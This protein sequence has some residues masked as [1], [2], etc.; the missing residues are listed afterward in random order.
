MH[1]ASYL[2]QTEFVQNQPDK[3]KKALKQELKQDTQDQKR[4]QR[5]VSQNAHTKQVRQAISES[6]A[7]DRAQD[8]ICVCSLRGLLDCCR[9]SSHRSAGRRKA[10]WVSGQQCNQSFA[11]VGR[12]NSCMAD[13]TIVMHNKVSLHEWP[14]LYVLSIAAQPY[15]ELHSFH[16]HKCCPCHEVVTNQQDLKF[17]TQDARELLPRFCI[18]VYV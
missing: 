9:L 17:S 10:R 1:C 5:F 18:I 15:I 12:C 11:C 16:R 8:Q 7:C 2:T 13:I 6:G 3:H 14:A 4:I